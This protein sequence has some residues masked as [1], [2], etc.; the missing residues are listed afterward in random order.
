MATLF[1][2]LRAA[3]AP[4]YELESELGAGG[5]G[6]VY[7]ARDVSLDRRVA[8][9]IIRPE[10]ATALAAE[11]FQREARLLA[12]LAHPNVVAV[13]RAGESGGLFYYVMDYVA[14]PTLAE[15]LERGPLPAAEAVRVGEDLLR[16]LAAAH[17][18]GVVHRDVKPGNIFLT[19]DRALLADFGIASRCA[20]DTA[21]LTLPGA[22]VGTPGYMAPEQAA[23]MAVGSQTDL[24]AV[25]VV[26]YEAVTG[27]KWDLPSS[28]AKADWSGVPR[29]LAVVL[30]RALAWLPADRFPDAERFRR[31][32]A[33]LRVRPYVR[34][35]VALASVGLVVGA[36]AVA[37][38]VG[39]RASASAES[40][41][42][43][44]VWIAPFATIGLAPEA[45]DSLT[46]LVAFDLAGSPDFRAVDGTRSGG[47]GDV[48]L[49]GTLR[50]ANG[51]RCATAAL[52]R[53]AGGPVT[54]LAAICAPADRMADLADSLAVRALLELWT[55]QEPLIADLP[56][57]ALPH[58]PWGVAAWAR[59]EHLFTQGRW[60][61]AHAAYAQAERA[62]STC[63]LCSWRLSTT[64]DWMS[65][66]HDTVRTARYL[67]HA[68]SFPPHYR[69][70]VRAKT[71]TMG[72]RLDSLRAAADRYPRFFFAWFMFGDELFHRGPLAG[73]SVSEAVQALERA[74][75]LGPGF[76]PAWEHLAW[77]AT[78]A[79]DSVRA[80]RALTQW[81]AAMGGAP[82]DEF[83]EGLI[84]Q[85]E[86]GYARR[87]HSPAEAAGL[88]GKF[89]QQPAIAASQYLIEGPRY[90]PTF[91]AP[92]GAVWLGAVFAAPGQPAALQ[93][94]G[95][96]ARAF[97][98][99]ALG[100]PDSARAT[101]LALVQRF[102]EPE[103][104]LF[105]SEYGGALVLA[106]SAGVPE[107][108]PA[109]PRALRHRAAP[110][111]GGRRESERARWMTALVSGE[112]DGFH[113]AAPLRALLDAWQ[114]GRV[115]RW[116]DAIARSDAV[117]LSPDSEPPD[118]ML[119]ALL[120]LG[121]GAW[122]ARAGGDPAAA[123]RELRWAVHEDV[124]G[125]LDVNPQAADVDWSF[126]TLAQW[127]LARVLDGA[128]EQDA[129]LCYAY[130]RVAALWAAGTPVY[131]ARAD[132]ARE[133]LN[134]L[135]AC[136]ATP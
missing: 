107:W 118:P 43:R 122:Y 2:R 47:A 83:S 34:R 52:Q 113:G 28:E 131:R 37:I 21:P 69:S 77:A 35:T 101:L 7:L 51:S 103:L 104:A 65:I 74:T 33:A 112:P 125:T 50:M 133:R 16:A 62:D 115:G 111:G 136:R 71:L 39:R 70:L 38:V 40:H 78:E 46:R 96:L 80:R 9:K 26:L 76:A 126:R 121:R 18:V 63:W 1:E 135:P 123:R 88:E 110:E 3:L 58:T 4:D 49:R 11:R 99:V 97:G 10:L 56:R 61:E 105:A 30:R 129:E 106:D 12:R 15:R 82:R 57:R 67:A 84:A 114:L 92:R 36:V 66:K 41:P 127:R 89:M 68:D 120:H 42:T 86:A 128:G 20:A 22:L 25:G 60:G 124:V 73:R 79:G 29:G 23:A 91:G 94:S 5:M 45:G 116:H 54:P 53:A 59:A 108:R 24:Y 87:F 85:I 81:M 72:P 93:R 64:E 119:R 109:I 132:T 19:P 13:H 130:R 117:R 17:R 8:I 75:E 102:P 48:E 27:R 134:Q 31:A 95:L 44:V 98:Y 100:Q 90:M 6:V 14:G 55:G 32:L